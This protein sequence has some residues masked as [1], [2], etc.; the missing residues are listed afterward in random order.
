M[1][2]LPQLLLLQLLQLLRQLAPFLPLALA[3]A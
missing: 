2:P 1:L 3:L